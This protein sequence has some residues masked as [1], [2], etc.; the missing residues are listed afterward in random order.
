MASY[1]AEYESRNLFRVYR[2]IRVNGESA[3][4][5]VGTVEAETYESAAAMGPDVERSTAAASGM[6][7]R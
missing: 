5:Y 3:S 4:R 2:E 7:N 6:K 1:T